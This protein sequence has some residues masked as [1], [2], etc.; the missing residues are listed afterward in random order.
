MS[1]PDD[2]RIE[3][4]GVIAMNGRDELCFFPHARAEGVPVPR[5]GSPS[6]VIDA[7]DQFRDAITDS[8]AR[9]LTRHQVEAVDPHWCPECGGSGEAHVNASN[10]PRDADIVPCPACGGEGVRD[11]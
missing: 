9:R 1:P 4:R 6:G 11:V 8:P 2:G 5:G 7:L 10:D 3:V